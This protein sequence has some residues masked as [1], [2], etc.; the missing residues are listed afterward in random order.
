MKWS[1]YI[2]ALRFLL[3]I[4]LW[5]LFF[6]LAVLTKF[7]P[8]PIILSKASALSASIHAG[9]FTYTCVHWGGA[10]IDG[11]C[12]LYLYEEQC[13]IIELLEHLCAKHSIVSAVTL[14]ELL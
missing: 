6:L 13:T 10:Q 8:F 12:R 5:R 14:T 9:I 4:I 3:E 11:K 7:L 2:F 1:I